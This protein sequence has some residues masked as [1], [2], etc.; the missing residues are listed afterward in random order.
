MFRAVLLVCAVLALGDA[1]ITQVSQCI[2]SSAG[3]VP[4]LTIVEGCGTPPCVV[5]QGQDAVISMVFQ[6]PRVIHNMKTLAMTYLLTIPVPLDLKELS[7]TCNFLINTYCPVEPGILIVYQLRMLIEDFWPIET[8]WPLEF[9]IVDDNDVTVTCAR[10]A[11]HIAPPVLEKL[12]AQN[13]TMSV[14]V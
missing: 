10:V 4:L 8:Q 5:P 6:A 1:Q 14:D 7:E 11:I 9:R 13:A 3:P 2:G 12:G